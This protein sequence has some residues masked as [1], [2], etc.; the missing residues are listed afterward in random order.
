V[1]EPKTD[2]WGFAADFLALVGSYSASHAASPTDTRLLLA[3]GALQRFGAVR[4]GA[5]CAS[6]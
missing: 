1:P 6:V 2:G 5:L 3:A 4:G